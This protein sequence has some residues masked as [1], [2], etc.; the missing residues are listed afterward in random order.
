MIPDNVVEE[1]RIRADLV[2]VVGEQVSLKRSGKEFKGLC[3]FHQEKTPSFYVVP[4]KGF[5]KCFGCGE[6][7]DVFTFLMKKGGLTF[8]DAVRALAG[9]VGVEVPEEREQE[10]DDPRKP[11]FEAVAFAADLYRRA[12]WEDAGAE[13]ARG[14]LERRGISREMAERFELGW[15]ADDFQG[16]R[17]A[18]HRHGMEDPVLLAAGLIKE[19]ERGGDPYDRFR[20]RLMFPVADVGGR[21]VAFGGRILKA[22]PKA[23]KYLNSPECEIFHK[24][25]MLYGLSWSR[26]AIRRE[27]AALVVEGYMDYIALAGRGVEHVVAGLGTAMTEE[28]ADLVGRYTGKAYLLY[29][30]DAAGLR[31]TFKSADALLRAGVHPLVVTLPVGED[32]DS[33]V[34]EGGAEALRPHLDAALP[35]LERKIAMLEEH[36]F[37][38]DSEGRRRAL[39][40]LLPTV[41]A[42]SDPVLQDIY[43]A[44]TAKRLDL[45]PETVRAEAAARARTPSAPTPGSGRA[46]PHPHEPRPRTPAMAMPT[47]PAER[48]LLMVLLQDPM[49][50]GPVLAEVGAGDFADPLNAEVFSALAAAWQSVTSSHLADDPLEAIRSALAAAPLGPAAAE[51]LEALATNPADLGPPE[52]VLADTVGTIKLSRLNREVRSVAERI[53]ATADATEMAALRLRHNALLAERRALAGT[54]RIGLKTRRDARTRPPP[55]TPE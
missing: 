1:V 17:A 11:L 45:Q 42:V 20:A 41:R 29:D 43:I 52:R 37:L 6:S 50:T 22:D 3:P 5:Y 26:H 40:K 31:A 9:R 10:G 49:R 13:E 18:A 7:G 38:D 33:L 35:V 47:H 39:D 53:G 55:E 25:R 19:S 34:R 36:G 48:M 51:R 16:L 14:Y 30:S 32:P 28:Q 15:A 27:G 21:T 54:A 4:Q 8:T 24:G 12:L 44:Q 23:P 46:R 2:E